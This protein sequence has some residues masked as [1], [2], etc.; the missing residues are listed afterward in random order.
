VDLEEK[1]RLQVF[2]LSLLRCQEK[3]LPEIVRLQMFAKN[4][5]IRNFFVQKLRAESCSR[6]M[7]TY[8][9][10]LEDGEMV[11]S[12]HKFTRNDSQFAS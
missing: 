12:S 1:M 9:N 4:I 6:E 10:L 7:D 2:F 5:Q 11:H 3:C 8:K